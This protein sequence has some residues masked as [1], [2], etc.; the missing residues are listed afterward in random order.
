LSTSYKTWATNRVG[1]ALLL[2][3]AATANTT[4]VAALSWMNVAAEIA[5]GTKA[6]HAA[7]AAAI[8]TPKH[9]R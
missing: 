5:A 9:R 2:V 7:K 8:Q 1:L 4:A 3:A 6:T